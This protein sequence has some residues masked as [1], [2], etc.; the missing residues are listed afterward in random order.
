MRRRTL[1]PL[2]FA[3]AASPWL[4]Q[5]AEPTPLTV[6][7]F[8]DLDRAAKAIQPAWDKANPTT[9]L[10]V[11]SR[12][13]ADHHHAMSAVLATGSGQPDVMA[14]D[15]RF[16][17]QFAAGGGLDD[18]RAAPYNAGPLL[19][20]LPR[21]SVVQGTS[22]KGHLVAMPTDIGPGTLLYRL[23][24]LTKAGLTEAEMTASWPAYLAAGTAMKKASGAALLTDAADLR[25]ILLRAGL[26]DGEGIY[27]DS[28]G[29]VLVNTERFHRAFEMGLAMRRAGL[30]L[31]ASPW[32]NEWAAAFRQ[33]RVSTQMMGCWLAGHMKNWLAPDQAGKWRA[34]GLP[35]GTV[36]SYGGSFYAIPKFA[37]NKAAAWRFIQH[38][39][40]DRATQLQSLRVLDAFPA[41][42]VAQ[43][44]PIMDE[45]MPYL[46]DQRARQLWR[47]VAQRVPA[48][49]VHKFDALATAIVRDAFEQVVAQG[50]GIGEVLAEAKSLIERRARR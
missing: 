1:L 26:Q 25:D 28:N 23:D 46:G 13:Y 12:Q 41:L 39:V 37:A 9:P 24:L 44:D 27:F 5:A 50:R 11:V 32:T 15:L 2:T 35:G 36:A 8:P 6:A 7:S 47:S 20:Q 30:D 22:P 40:F 42:L 33:G 16:I 18:L 43:Q 38:M 3:S 17:G 34:A 14:L 29:K 4:A 45:T 10:K 31:K 49:P 48:T 21:F 19:P